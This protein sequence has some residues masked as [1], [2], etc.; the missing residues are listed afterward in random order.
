[1]HFFQFEGKSYEE[2]KSALRKNDGYENRSSGPKEED[3]TTDV[4]T[5]SFRSWN[6]RRFV[7]DSD[8][9]STISENNEQIGNIES[10]VF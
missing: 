5:V 7:D 1:M 6:H 3:D 4:D 8:D 2:L 9:D 10:Y